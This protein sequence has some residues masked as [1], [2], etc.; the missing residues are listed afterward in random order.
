ME[1]QTNIRMRVAEIQKMELP[2]LRK[3]W[4]I[5]FGAEAPDCGKNFLRRQLAYRVQEKFYG[6]TLSDAT[7]KT[8]TAV[9]DA[10]KPRLNAAGMLSG[11][12]FE[13]EWK[14]KTYTLIVRDEGFDLEGKHFKTLSGAAFAI[15]GTQWNGKKFFGVK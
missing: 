7:I 5:E 12:K 14:G 9:A 11:T 4:L 10:P 1:N 15:T 3:H 2:D 8:M 13:R 6:I